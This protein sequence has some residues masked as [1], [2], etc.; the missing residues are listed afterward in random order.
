MI[1]IRKIINK[2]D[3]FN[4]IG[5]EQYSKITVKN[6]KQRTLKNPELVSIYLYKR[7]NWNDICTVIG[8]CQAHIDSQVFKNSDEDL[9][10]VTMIV[11]NKRNGY[12]TINDLRKL[13]S[14]EQKYK[15]NFSISNNI[16]KFINE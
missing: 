14:L 5:N 2:S 11:F 6:S 15:I 7:F 16:I 12:I 3:I 13:I 9:S 1:R 10:F 4:Y 8:M